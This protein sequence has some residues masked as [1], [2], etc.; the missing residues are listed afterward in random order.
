MLGRG[1]ARLST[2]DHAVCSVLLAV[3]AEN[4]KATIVLVLLL[5]IAGFTLNPAIYGRVFTLTAAAPTLAGSTTVSMFQLCISLVP[6]FAG[7]AI[8]EGAGLT[9]IPWIGAGLAVLAV[10]VILFDQTI[11]QRQS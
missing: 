10:P 9:A 2:V 1:I 3:F 4:S 6:V 11:T 5:G 8:N 7:I